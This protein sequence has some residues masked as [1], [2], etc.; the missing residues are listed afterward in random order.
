[1]IRVVVAMPV[2]L[3]GFDFLRS[4]VALRFKVGQ[5]VI[6]DVQI[7]NDDD[8][9]TDITG[10]SYTAQIGPEGGS[11]I[12]SLSPSMVDA[13]LGK[14]RFTSGSTSGLTPGQYVWEVWENGDNF[15]WSGPVEIVA[16]SL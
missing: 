7:V 3:D 8:V 9:P 5:A 10:R 2:L 12:A 4:E 15:L 1:M 6:I 16:R 11:V 14:L 13:V